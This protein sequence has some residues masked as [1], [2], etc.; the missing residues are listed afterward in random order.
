MVC[1]VLYSYSG[2]L[3]PIDTD[4]IVGYFPRSIGGMN[5]TADYVLYTSGF[6]VRKSNP[7]RQFP[8]Q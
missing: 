5:A 3:V 1:L 2:D 8:L 7:R 4:I 6:S